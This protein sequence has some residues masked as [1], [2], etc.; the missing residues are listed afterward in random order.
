MSATERTFARIDTTLKGYIRLLPQGRFQPL[1]CGLQSTAGLQVPETVQAEL[2][3]GLIQY[4]RS[5]DE[6][7]N[8]L[9]TLLTQQS[10][11]EDFPIPAVVH[12]ISG[13]GLRF[14]SPHDF[15]I[16]DQLEM[17]VALGHQAQGLAGTTGVIIR[18]DERDGQTLWAFGFKELRDLER[19]KIIQFVVARQREELRGRHDSTTF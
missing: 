9:L 19:E 7:L 10:L 15:A 5:M 4:L 18:R 11:Q 2:P 3:D 16:G 1:F 14:S 6:K 17:V 12:D 8:S 13:A